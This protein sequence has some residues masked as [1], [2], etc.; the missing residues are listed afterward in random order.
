MKVE[1]AV[2][3]DERVRVE[4]VEALSKAGAGQLRYQSQKGDWQSVAVELARNQPTLSD[5]NR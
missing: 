3:R 2:E 1:E 5:D 4:R